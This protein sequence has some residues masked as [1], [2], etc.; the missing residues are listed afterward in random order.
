LEALEAA[1]SHCSNSEIQFF[2]RLPEVGKR[3]LLDIFNEISL[4]AEIRDSWFRTKVVP[5][6]KPRN[7]PEWPWD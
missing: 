2:K 3:Y 6:L 1:F 7:D 4:T 5:I